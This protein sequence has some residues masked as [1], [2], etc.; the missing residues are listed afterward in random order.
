MTPTV[1]RTIFEEPGFVRGTALRQVV[2]RGSDPSPSLWRQTLMELPGSELHNVYGTSESLSGVQWRSGSP[3]QECTFV[4]I[5]RIGGPVH[6][7]DEQGLPA[8]PG[9]VG[10]IHIGGQRHAIGYLREGR[11]DPLPLVR[12]TDVLADPL[13]RTGDMGVVHEGGWI[14]YR[15]RESGDPDRLG[16][17][18]LERTAS[19]LP[20]VRDVVVVASATEIAMFY[21]ADPAGHIDPGQL[22]AG[23]AARVSRPA[24]PHRVN[25]IPLLPIGKPDVRLLRDWLSRSPGEVSCGP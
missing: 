6:V 15:G 9:T 11:L 7:V 1:W 16:L 10:D 25:R 23:F 3:G 4:P 12:P 2:L 20:G 19:L 24:T 18:D 22:C 14:E 8:A 13:Y 17:V 5:G 21:S